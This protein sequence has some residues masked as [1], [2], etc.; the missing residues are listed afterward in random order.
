MESSDALRRR[1][2]FLADHRSMAEMERILG[3]FLANSL[4]HMDDGACH[5][6]I[7]LLQQSDAD[8]L[9]WMSA[10]KEPPEGVDREVL[11]WLSSYSTEKN[12]S[13]GRR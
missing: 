3:R 11:S 5:R 8:L 1:L 6:V 4:S 7:D 12:Q 9:D 13:R 10:L 2:A